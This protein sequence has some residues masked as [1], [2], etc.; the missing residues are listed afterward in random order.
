MSAYFTTTAKTGSAAGQIR[1]FALARHAVGYLR[2]NVRRRMLANE[3]SRL[4]DRELVDIGL[5]RADV[6]R[7]STFGLPAFPLHR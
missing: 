1:P 2:A 3:L 4:S 7:P 5:S 6:P